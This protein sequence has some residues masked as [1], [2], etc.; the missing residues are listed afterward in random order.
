MKALRKK[1]WNNVFTRN[2]EIY[3][4]YLW[5]RME[6]FSTVLLG[7][8]GTGKGT[9]AAAIGRS[10]FIPFD[11]NT[12]RFVETFPHAF[13][14]LNLS[15]FPE[16]LIESEL[17]GHKKGAFTGAVEDFRGVF[18]RCSPF[19]AI[20]LDEIGEVSEP[21]QIKLLQVIQ[22]RWFTPVGSHEKHRFQGRV[23]AATNRTMG[24]LRGS[25]G[26][27]DDFYYR[28]CSDVIVVPPLRRRIQE[29]DGELDDLLAH[30]L[31]RIMGAPSPELVESVK[32]AILVSPGKDYEWPGN[33]RELEQRV[34]RILLDPD[35]AGDR[36]FRN[37]DMLALLQSGIEGGS[38]SARDL[39]SGYC[40]MLHARIGSYEGVAR[41]TGLDRRTVRKYIQEK[42]GSEDSSESHE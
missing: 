9:A 37:T 16:S 14:A 4:Q 10:G 30:T 18:D 34:R 11:E 22:E 27:R 15:R 24:E 26:L 8:T 36:I 19:G 12:G 6:D 5:N 2:L 3:N 23:I 39:L 17:F 32:K 20:F 21:V 38:L 35:S 31:E 7:E 40:R 28:L 42:S 29:D 13:V 41:R 1:L 25:G 33:V